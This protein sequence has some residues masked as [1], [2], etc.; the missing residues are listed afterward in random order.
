MVE[1]I[2]AG[3]MQGMQAMRGMQGPPPPEQMFQK[4]SLDAGGDGSSVTKDQ[5]QTLVD[6][7]SAQGMDTTEFEALI[8]KFDEISGGDSSITFKDLNSAIENGTLDKPKGPPPRG[9]GGEGPDYSRP[10]AI[11][12]DAPVDYSV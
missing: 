9:Q 3:G 11:N 12:T 1:G 4:M 5:L 2:S 6:N 7:A 8:S 10:F